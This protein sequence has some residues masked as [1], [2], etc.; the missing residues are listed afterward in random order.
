MSPYLAIEN[1]AWSEWIARRYRFAP[2]SVHGCVVD[3]LAVLVAPISIS[4]ANSA[5]LSVYCACRAHLWV[6]SPNPCALAGRWPAQDGPGLPHPDGQDVCTPEPRYRLT[7][8][9]K[10]SSRTG[11]RT[12]RKHLSPAV[13][14]AARKGTADGDL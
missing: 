12:S 2:D 9:L 6:G 14:L 13:S 3:R 8:I 4:L 1:G 11:S 7:S 5:T 10:P